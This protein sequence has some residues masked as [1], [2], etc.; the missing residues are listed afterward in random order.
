MGP[1]FSVA[2]HSTQVH[3]LGDLEKLQPGDAA[4]IFRNEPAQE[5][6]MAFQA[7]YAWPQERTDIHHLCVVGMAD[8]F[9]K[10]PE[11]LRT[12]AQGGFTVLA[13]KMR[14]DGAVESLLEFVKTFGP[15]LMTQEIQEMISQMA[16]E[17]AKG[18][19]EELDEREKGNGESKPH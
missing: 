17:G 2:R 18:A 11:M 13:E 5:G 9:A 19:N 8:F 7:I 15:A 6:K 12:F 14:E 1:E 4:I 16:V 10:N 3:E